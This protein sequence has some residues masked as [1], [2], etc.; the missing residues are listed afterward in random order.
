MKLKLT[1]WLLMALILLCGCAK[2]PKDGAEGENNNVTYD[3]PDTAGLNITSIKTQGGYIPIS[4]VKDGKSQLS[5]E[6]YYYDI[7]NIL[8]LEPTLE[9]K[10]LSYFDINGENVGADTGENYTVLSTTGNWK[11][12]ADIRHQTFTDP[13][14]SASD[15]YKQFISESMPEIF[16]TVADVNVSDIWEYDIDSDNITEAVVAA[17]SDDV[18]VLAVL[19]QTLG[20]KMLAFFP[21]TDTSLAAAYFL[22]IDGNGEFSL[23]TVS[24]NAYKLVTVYKENTLD[25]DYSVYL[26]VE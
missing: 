21:K 19:S 14:K 25:P 24:G 17:C 11:L 23:V 26:P 2:S 9:D 12:S 10:T 4:V 22:D 7:Q 18:S 13:K 1:A 8:S 16:P 20:N 5:G 3:T 6:N 15:G